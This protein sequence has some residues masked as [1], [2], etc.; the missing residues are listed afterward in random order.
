M[1]DAPNPFEALI[2]SCFD[3]LHDASTVQ[4]RVEMARSAYRL[5]W[6]ADAL[7]MG[8]IRTADMGCSGAPPEDMDEHNRI[9]DAY[10]AARYD[11]AVKYRDRTGYPEKCASPAQIAA[12]LDSIRDHLAKGL[13]ADQI[14]ETILRKPTV[15]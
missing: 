11:I 10:N 1:T 3:L 14:R 12:V 4:E 9:S 6:F 2:R 13:P 7:A 5:F 15:Q 8:E